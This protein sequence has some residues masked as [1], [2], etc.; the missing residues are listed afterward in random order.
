[1]SRH[2]K[3][4][5]L[6]IA[7]LA[8][9]SIILDG[10]ALAQSGTPGVG[11]GA[12]FRAS[13]HA[14]TSRNPPDT[15]GAVGPNHV[16]LLING[17]YEVY[18]KN[19]AL[20]TGPDGVLD[21]DPIVESGIGQFWEDIFSQP[22]D[23]VVFDPRVTYDPFEKRWYAV[24]VD[25]G[26]SSPPIVDSSKY[27]FA[28]SDTED[29]SGGWTGFKIS[30]D[31]LSSISD[32][33]RADFPMLGFDG[34]NVY[35]ST[36]NQLSGASS[37]AL[38]AFPKD[39]ILAPNPTIRDGM[40]NLDIP[41]EELEVSTSGL[42]TRNQ[43]V[44]ALDNKTLQEQDYHIWKPD[45]A[46]LTVRSVTESGSDITVS[47]SADVDFDP[48]QT[49]EAADLEVNLSFARQPGITFAPDGSPSNH[50]FF[51]M[52][53]EF[54]SIPIDPDPERIESRL[55]RIDGSYWGVHMRNDFET[56]ED[57]TV[58]RWF[59]IDAATLT[60][61]QKGV[62]EIDG[63]DVVYPSISVNGDGDVVI[64]FTATGPDDTPGF[65]QYA[66]AYA[67]VGR[68]DG[69][70]ETT[71]GS[72]FALKEG[73]AVY[74]HAGH[75]WGDYTNTVNDPADPNIFWTFQQWATDSEDWSVQSSELIVY[76][77]DEFYWAVD[78][79]GNFDPG[80]SWLQGSAPG[81]GDHAI[82]SRTG[83]PITVD[84]GLNSTTT[85]TRASV[86]QGDVTWRYVNAT[87]NLTSA[88]PAE[89]ALAIAEYQ[90]TA[91]LSINAAIYGS[92][93]APNIQVGSQRS[94]PSSLSLDGIL[95][96]TADQ[97]LEVYEGST[98]T[99]DAF[100]HSISSLVVGTPNE[101]AQ[102]K[103]TAYLNA[104]ISGG[105]SGKNISILPDGQM[106]AIG[107]ITM[108]PVSGSAI[109]NQGILEVGLTP[110]EIST[111]V[112]DGNPVAGARD[113]ELKQV[114]SDS[115]VVIDVQDLAPVS[116]A[117]D[118]ITAGTATLDGDLQF[119]IS[120]ADLDALSVGDLATIISLTD[121]DH[122][123][124]GTPVSGIFGNVNLSVD[125][126][127]IGPSGDFD[128]GFAVLYPGDP[129]D[130]TMTVPDDQVILRASIPGDVNGDGRVD[131]ADFGIVSSNFGHPGPH[132]WADGNVNGDDYVD[133]AD[134]AVLFAHWTGD[135]GP[136]SGPQ[137]PEPSSIALL[138]IPLALAGMLPGRNCQSGRGCCELS[139]ENRGT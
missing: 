36:I 41:W 37:A 97:G 18:N 139:S 127:E 131:A 65:E 19:P 70:G 108:N 103:A 39:R 6:L 78:A 49:P 8:V 80:A 95:F 31:E 98:A 22:P 14:E 57:D 42:V 56:N 17:R 107:D 43:V 71:F 84:F 69:L 122:G 35:M 86:R 129:Y 13:S 132:S 138:L 119:K 93:V 85:N 133:A 113:R 104:G 92:L 58:I 124:A 117:I 125:G 134:I 32:P 77:D 10:Q 126:I 61:K 81:S 83:Q 100:F 99:L 2:T 75:R 74:D 60:E 73:I 12:N 135:P 123:V 45:D 128:I 90:G 67:V 54:N 59:E 101:F 24:S 68:T 112:I 34:T 106:F 105:Y 51:L 5:V 63:Q 52:P 116:P 87:Y 82:F 28:V 20:V 4:L 66:S 114:G 38:V 109:E 102:N 62:I 16:M 29:P 33:E 76:D 47:P 55:I 115:V 44:R 46:K 50:N 7:T 88:S 25:R 79:D 130:V 15:M 27:L 21:G 30:A 26:S 118:T 72:P 23:G 120:Q 11:I 96:V 48:L 64:G 94:G 40:G 111:F 1:M 3:L 136:G 91:S 89:P 53:G 110:G 137:V 121:T 9:T